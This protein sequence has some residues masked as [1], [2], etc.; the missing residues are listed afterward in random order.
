MNQADRKAKERYLERLKLIKSGA[1]VNPFE[2]REE[3]QNRIKK[4]K[5]DVDFFVKEYLS[6]LAPSDSADFHIELA[7][8]VKRNKKIKV[9]IRWGRGLAKSVW[10]D[11]I[12][13]LWLWYRGEQVFLVLVGNNEKKAKI[14]L[15]DIQAEFE[16]NSKLIHDCGEQKQVGSWEDGDF[17]TRDLR[18]IG[19]AIG[20]GQ[21]PRGLR[22]GPYRPNLI[23]PDDLEDKNTVK[24]PKIQ[25]EVVKWIEQDL[26]PTMDGETRRYLQPNNNP[27]PRSIQEELR[28][29][30]PKW[31]L[32]QVNACDKDTRAPR[33]KAKYPP[34]YY[35]E[36]DEEIGTLAVDAEYNNIPHVEGKVFTQDMIHYAKR[37]K[38]NHFKVI[39]AHWDIAYSGNNDHNS[40]RMMGLYDYYFW[41]IKAFNRQCKMQ[42]AIRWMYI[43]DMMLPDSVI[44]HWR[45]EK[46][47]WTQ[48]VE[49]ALEE[50]ADEF[51]YQLPISIVDT[52][53]GHKYD[54]I[55]TMHPYYQMGR[56]I[57]DEKLKS[58]KH[59]EVSIAQL[60]GMEPGYSCH[61]DGPDA[62]EQCIRYLSSFIVRKS[63]KTKNKIDKSQPRRK[64]WRRA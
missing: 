62:E 28:L 24:N 60:K 26:I 39:A 25:D 23:I 8:M 27:F 1:V 5:Q 30:H 17:N 19:M 18:F 33:W 58:C 51:G 34:E 29:K 10:A 45:A 21:S 43:T 56:V 3:Q 36:L 16:A 37:P 6:H 64:N 38:L 48:P 47:F 15:S 63:S 44:V 7:N 54:R 22:K 59:T 32:H 42:E 20:M 49:D 50:V 12:I 55:L 53:K 31:I 61:D 52:G 11:I 57:Y 4:A 9:L 14:L 46:Q 41:H 35:H 40:V 2:T 13:P